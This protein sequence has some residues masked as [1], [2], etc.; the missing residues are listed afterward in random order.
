MLAG[1]VGPMGRGWVLRYFQ[2]YVCS[3]HFGGNFEYQSF[4]E[5]MNILGYEGIM[6]IWGVIIKFDYFVR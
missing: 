1:Y 4:L 5:K 3:D 2:T 6:D